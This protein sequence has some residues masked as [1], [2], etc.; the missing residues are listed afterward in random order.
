M[1]KIRI[2]A[3]AI[4]ILMTGILVLVAPMVY[5]LI[6]NWVNESVQHKQWLNYSQVGVGVLLA[7]GGFMQ[8]KKRRAK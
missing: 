8:W 4:A 5:G 7:I 6:G 3:A 1:L 2:I